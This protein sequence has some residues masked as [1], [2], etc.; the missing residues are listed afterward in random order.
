MTWLVVIHDT[1]DQ[2]RAWAHEPEAKKA[3]VQALRRWIALG[4]KAEDLGPIHSH[5]LPEQ[6]E[7]E[8]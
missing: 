2:I 6:A 7:E 8:R 5:E 4:L 3:L 1:Q